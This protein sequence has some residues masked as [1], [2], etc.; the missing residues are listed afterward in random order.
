MTVGSVSARR[1]TFLPFSTP[2]IGEEEIR[3][4]VDTLRSRWITTGPKAKRFESEFATYLQAPGALALSSCTAALHT[5]L[6]TLGIGPGDEVITTPM[7]FTATVNVIEHVGARPVLADVEPDT[8]NIDAGEVEAA[9]TPRTRAI[10]PVHYAGHPVDLDALRAL[11]RVYRLAIIED[12]AHAL[13]ARYKGQLIGGGGNPVAF[14]FYAIKNLTTAEGGMLTA[15]PE[16]L[17]QARVVSLHGMSRDA[18]KRYDQGGGWFYEVVL[19]GFKYN[20]T[21][22]QAALGLC[23]LRKLEQFQRRR[24]EIVSQYNRAFLD[25]PA[26]ELPVTRP[27]VEHA[28]HLYALRLRLEALTISRDRFIEELAERNIGTSVHFIPIH[29]HPYYRDRYGFTPA[30]FPVA[31]SNYQRLLS[32][33]LNPALTDQDVSDVI[34]GVLDVLRNHRV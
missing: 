15:D 16:F 27:E 26:L 17:A 11:A 33:P 32:L 14:S 22:I 1:S 24:R 29:L 21:D 10:L 20:M 23:Q 28:W 34:E 5:A 8:L 9:I 19:P 31:C 13:P 18:W 12:A 2:T 7:T 4:V 30:S 25:E 6:K 3:E